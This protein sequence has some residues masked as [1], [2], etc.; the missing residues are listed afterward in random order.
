M[1][2]NFK[3][4]NTINHNIDLLHKFNL[5]NKNSLKI[6]NNSTRDIPNLNVLKCSNSGVIVL[7]SFIIPEDYYEKNI[8]YTDEFKGRIETAK[9]MI[10]SKPLEDDLRRF[11]SYK[12]L[13][14]GSEILD[15]GC[16]R[17]DFIKLSKKISKRSVGLEINK[18]NRDYLNNIGVQCVNTLTELNDDKFD[19]ITLNHVFEHLNDPINILVELQKHLNDDGIII[20]EVPHARD[21]LLETFNLESFKNFTFWSEHLILH[22]RKSLERFATNSGLKLKNIEGFQRYKI[23]NHFNWLL[24]GQPSGHE[25]FQDLNND[26]FHSSYIKLLD[27]IDQTDTLIGY[28]SKNI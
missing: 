2:D 4:N 1:N 3:S 9:G 23:S 22:T 20:I 25:I 19:L 11:E 5:S 16:G 6:F 26:D 7:E 17:G 24:N 18:K 8:H 21:L 14:K 15:F 10:E 28:F 12:E 13:I 27:S